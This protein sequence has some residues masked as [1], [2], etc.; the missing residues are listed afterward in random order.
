[1]ASSYDNEM[2]G[3]P[4]IYS[5]NTRKLK[6]YF[7]EPD[8]GINENTGILLLIAGFGGNA[9]SNVYKKMR[10]IFADKYNLV[11]IQCDYFGWE[12]MQDANN[13]SINMEE[14]Q[15]EK[16]FNIDEMDYI[17]NKENTFTRLMEVCSNKSINVMGKENFSESLD[18]YN[19]MGLIQAIDNISAVVSVIEI[20]EN[21]EYKINMNK[22]IL[23]G[24][25]HG[26]YLAY[27]A[28]AFAPHMFSLLIDNSAWLFP[29]YLKKNRYVKLMYGKS[30]LIVEFEYLAKTL[31][32]DE[33]I[34]CLPSLYK[35]LDNQCEIICYHGTD[36]KLIS[37]KDK[38]E[39]KKIIKN[40][41]Y[42]EISER[43]VDGEIFKSPEHGLDADFLKLFDYVMNHNK[44]EFKNRDRKQQDMILYETQKKRYFI[45]Y[46]N[47]VPNIK[48]EIKNV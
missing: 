43:E 27:L 48:I 28:N 18:N 25:S 42:Y 34:L 26:A 7:S 21:N 44:F 22:I 20:I 6:V 41:T 45:N 9:N 30:E 14:S 33:E 2:Y 46:D 23:Y 15:K 47:I 31:D 40:F 5:P 36:D 10:D 1:M 8:A 39:L 37:N 3:H 16:W 24:H 29:R 17:F 11:T 32:Y 19:D 4:S 35:K 12:F 38:M 13:I